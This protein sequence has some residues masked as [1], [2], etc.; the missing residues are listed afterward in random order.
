[1]IR[2]AITMA[3]MTIYPMVLPLRAA[4]M[5]ERPHQDDQHEYVLHPNDSPRSITMGSLGPYA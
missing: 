5:V 3:M 2:A 4:K 1:M